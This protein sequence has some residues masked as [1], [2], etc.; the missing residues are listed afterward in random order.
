M[1][2]PLKNYAKGIRRDRAKEKSL[3]PDEA[4]TLKI[5]RR[6]AKKR[7][8]SLATGGKGGLPPSL[9]LG[10]MRRDNFECKVCGS[11]EM[12]SIHH[13]G[14]ILSSPKMIRRGHSNQP[15]NLVT[16][17]VECHDALHESARDDGTDSTNIPV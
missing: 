9:V 3:S 4:N 17:C 1:S 11:Q 14:G 15:N 10:V 13:K 8:T 2:G 5:L 16:I 7:G 6:E 12:I